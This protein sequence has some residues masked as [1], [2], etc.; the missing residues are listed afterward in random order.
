MSKESHLTRS[1]ELGRPDIDTIIKQTVEACDRD[2]RILVAASGPDTLL[3]NTRMAV[4]S[5]M[6]SH[7]ASIHLHLEEFGW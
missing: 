6:S 2:D 1:I 3:S 4:K 5:S 7:S